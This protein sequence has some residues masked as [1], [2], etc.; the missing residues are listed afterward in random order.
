MVCHACGSTVY[1]DAHLDHARNYVSTDILRR[2]L[3]DSFKFKILFA[4][5]KADV[6]DKK[7]S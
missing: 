7:C 3:Q 4:M 5:N 2:I 6:D 1:D